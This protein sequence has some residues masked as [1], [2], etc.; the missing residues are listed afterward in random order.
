MKKKK[1]EG[2]IR[3]GGAFTFGPVYWTQCENEP[4][5]NLTIK[6][7]GEKAQIMPACP[8]CW[9]KC[10][11]GEDIDGLKIVKADPIEKGA[12]TMKMDIDKIIKDADTK[13]NEW[14]NDDKTWNED[15]DGVDKA[16]CIT[17]S[18]CKY[19]KILRKIL[20]EE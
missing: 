20:I 4:T 8:S 6:R 1:C 14:L 13:F 10:I 5:V 16:D 9:K 11:D 12:E 18:I 15:F 19:R 7:K 3:H 17:T 2:Q